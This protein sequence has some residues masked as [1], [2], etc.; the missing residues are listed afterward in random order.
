VSATF[1]GRWAAASTGFSGPEPEKKSSTN[2]P[3]SANAIQNLRPVNG[4]DEKNFMQKPV[5][6]AAKG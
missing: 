6:T 1:A 5:S 2:T 4:P 3:N